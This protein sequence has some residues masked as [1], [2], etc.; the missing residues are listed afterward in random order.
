MLTALLWEKGRRCPA[1]SRRFGCL[2]NGPSACFR[3]EAVEGEQSFRNERTGPSAAGGS[4]P[5]GVILG[6][7][8]QFPSCLQALT[9]PDSRFLLL[10]LKALGCDE[11]GRTAGRGC[12]P[13]VGVLGAPLSLRKFCTG[14]GG[15]AAR[16]QSRS[17]GKNGG[18]RG[19]PRPPEDEA[20]RGSLWRGGGEKGRS[21]APACPRQVGE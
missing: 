3:E 7:R 12:C 9:P 19:S 10:G 21:L 18:G 16:G 13:W 8:P 1:S 2:R 6:S 20:L 4:Y 17:L 11:P 15:D 14:R 5:R